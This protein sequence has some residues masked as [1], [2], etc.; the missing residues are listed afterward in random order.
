MNL[1]VLLPLDENS[2]TYI[3][4]QRANLDFDREVSK[5]NGVYYFSHVLALNLPDWTNTGNPRLFKPAGSHVAWNS[6]TNPNTIVP[7]MFRYY[8][9]NICRLNIS[10]TGESATEEVAELAFWKTLNMLQMTRAEIE[11]SIVFHNGIFANNFIETDTNNGW[12]EIICQIPN[13][14]KKMTPA[15][16]TLTKISNTVY[17]TVDDQSPCFDTGSQY[18]FTNFN[19]ALDFNNFVYNETIEQDFSFNVLLLFYTDSTGVPKLHGINFI[20]PFEVKS[21]QEYSMQ[22]L[23]HR[24]NKVKSVGYQFIFN[25]KS[26]NNQLNKTYYYDQN[27]TLFYVNQFENVM[28]KFAQFFEAVRPRIDYNFT[29]DID[30][31]I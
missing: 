14:C 4:F 9:E 21:G 19:K 22:R 30:K 10:K 13:K 8:T 31:Y 28:G 15:W 17:G 23:K 6:I 18:N 3:T 20:H 5:A 26:V 2:S 29:I 25:L 12:V 1:P 27:A 11:S 7:N 16:R 24:T